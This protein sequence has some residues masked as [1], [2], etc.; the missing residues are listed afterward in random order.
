MPQLNKKKYNFV[1]ERKRFSEVEVNPR[2]LIPAFE[3]KLR[4]SLNY[5]RLKNLWLSKS[6]DNFE[7][8]LSFP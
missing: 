5:E 3:S 1:C 6:N 4:D 8:A 2:D 7:R